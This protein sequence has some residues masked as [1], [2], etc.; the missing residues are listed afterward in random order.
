M[1]ARPGS[2]PPEAQ[3]L[4]A[5]AILTGAYV[6]S[7]DVIIPTWALCTTFVFIMTRNAASGSNRARARITWRDGD[8]LYSDELVID[9]ASLIFSGDEAQLRSYFGAWE[10]PDVTV[11]PPATV[12]WDISFSIP[13]A[14]QAVRVSVL[15]AGDAANPG[16]LEVRVAFK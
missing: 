5:A 7:P 10:G 8:T 16:T 15:E 4:R 2:L 13:A 6:A 14:K 9:G 3:T 1:A 11:A 12:A